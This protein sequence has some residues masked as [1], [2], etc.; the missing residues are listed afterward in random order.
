MT[1]FTWK[2]FALLALVFACLMAP[3]WPQ[4]VSAEEVFDQE[5]GYY[6]QQHEW[7]GDLTQ[8]TFDYHLLLEG[9]NAFRTGSVFVA[10][11]LR[12]QPDNW[13]F[14]D[15]VGNWVM[16]IPGIT[17]PIYSG[18]YINPVER[19]AILREPTDVS[20]FIGDGEFWVGWGFSEIS[21]EAAFQDMLDNGRAIMVWR[22]GDPRRR[23]SSKTILLYSTKIDV[24]DNF[25][26]PFSK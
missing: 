17:P 2:Q 14:L 16:Y 5:M 24:F 15:S 26:I 12:S 9:D 1:T 3:A 4:A 11:H 19:I 8:L 6:V 18:R 13:W 10:F 25:S 23:E 20:A 22:V 21:D 7:R